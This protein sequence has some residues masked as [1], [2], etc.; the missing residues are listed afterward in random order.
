MA[1]GDLRPGHRDAAPHDGRAR[2]VR[3]AG[4]GPHRPGRH[5][6][7]DRLGGRRGGGDAERQRPG[8]QAGAH[9]GQRGAEKEVL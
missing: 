4:A 8:P 6:G 9:R 7:A 5:R 1:P 3:R 2:G